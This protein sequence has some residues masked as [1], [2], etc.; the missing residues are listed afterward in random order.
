M[1]DDERSR[2]MFRVG[3]LACRDALTVIADECEGLDGGDEG[4]LQGLCV[5]TV[6]TLLASALAHDSPDRGKCIAN[7]RDEL[8]RVPD[9][10]FKRIADLAMGFDVQALLQ[11]QLARTGNA[12]E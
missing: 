2:L 1:N 10:S 6:V 4:H 11:E 8:L 9:T 3:I 12:P 5:V 7:I